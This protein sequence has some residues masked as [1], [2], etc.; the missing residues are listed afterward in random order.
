MIRAL[1]LSLAVFCSP[2]VALIYP[3]Q[4]Q[5]TDCIDTHVVQLPG[6]NR[7]LIGSKPTPISTL[8]GVQSHLQMQAEVLG[9]E[10]PVSIP[11]GSGNDIPQAAAVDPTGNI[12]IVGNTDSDDFTL[13][14]PIVSRKIPYRTAG[15]VVELDASRSKVLFATYLAGARAS[16]TYIIYST[17]ATAIAFDNAGNAYVGG[18]TNEADFPTTPGAF[19]SGKGGYDGFGNTSVYSYLVKFSPTGAVIYSTEL[20]T[21]ISICELGQCVSGG[22]DSTEGN[23]TSVF[24]DPGGAATVAGLLNGRV[25]QGGGY[26]LRVSADASKLLWSTQVE[27]NFTS[28]Y[29]ITSLI[30]ASDSSTGNVDLFGVYAPIAF[31][32]HASESATSSYILGIPA[33]FAAQLKADG[34]GYNYSFDLGSASDAQIAGIVVDSS[35]YA[36]L[37]GS[38]SSAK[39]IPPNGIPNIGPDFV[40]QL[41][42]SGAQLRAP[43]HLPRGTIIGPPLLDS[44]DLSLMLPGPLNSLLTMPVN[45][46]FD[47]PAIVRICDSASFAGGGLFPGALRTIF[48]FDLPS[49]PEDVQIL[50]YGS[51]APLLYVSPTQ[52]NMQVPFGVDPLRMQVVFPSETVTFDVPV[53]QALGI[54]TTD[55]V[56]ASALNEDGTVNSPYNRAAAGSVVSL[57]GTGATWPAGMQDGAIATS[58]VP[59]PQGLNGFAAF[60]WTKT[61]LN[62]LYAGS[63]PGI[64]D[65]VFQVNVQL[66]PTAPPTTIAPRLTVQSAAL[67]ANPVQIYMK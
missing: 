2:S 56:H 11:G 12:W 50:F 26:V 9:S 63:A 35:G 3:E 7:I 45:Y 28:N 65:G 4:F 49:S 14:N 36:Y 64:I 46:N 16:N 66:P 19:L 17:V 62:I 58:A 6:G 24:A 52:I 22:N 60:D 39:L 33:L 23:V 25:Y 55:G 15:F 54:F 10:G 43:L 41:D 40:L 42:S 20:T 5:C 27:L 53:A 30:A 34:S 61:P 29:G 44:R 48:G 67:S 32:G 51:I 38:S 18:S 57:F 8:A 59:L 37:T 13:V 47:T 31:V 1:F 21:G